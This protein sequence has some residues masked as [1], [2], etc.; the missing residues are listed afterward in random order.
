MFVECKIPLQAYPSSS[1]QVDAL[2]GCEPWN[3]TPRWDSP[4]WNGWAGGDKQAD[5]ASPVR[6]SC[7]HEAF[8]QLVL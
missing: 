2:K 6:T 1:S 3:E 4:E 7:L 5:L 8:D